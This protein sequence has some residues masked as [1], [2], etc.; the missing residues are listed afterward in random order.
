MEIPPNSAGFLM[1]HHDN[2]TDQVITTNVRLNAAGLETPVYTTTETLI[3]YDGEIA[4][5][6]QST[7]HYEGTS[8]LLPAG[9]RFWRWSMRAHRNAVRMTALDGPD[10]VYQGLDWS[11]PGAWT[12]PSPPFLTFNS[13]RVTHGCTY[14]N[15]TTRTIR[16]GSSQQTEEECI[17]VG[18]FF[19]ATKPLLCYNG[20]V[21]P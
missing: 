18:Y 5:P 19:P 20:I 1:I 14:D 17:A 8:C 7:G 9:K 3:A 11:H 4:I 21:V 12:W 10:V 13:T 16:V 6:P 2:P 15:P